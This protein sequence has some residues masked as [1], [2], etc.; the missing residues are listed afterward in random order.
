MERHGRSGP[1]QA[2]ETVLLLGTGGVSSFALQFAKLHGA[3]VVL[4]SSSDA[5]LALAK[6]LGADDVINY[7]DTPDWGKAEILTDGRGVDMVVE[8][9]GPGTLER[10]IR[11]TRVGGH[12]HHWSCVGHRANRSTAADLASDPVAR[13]SCRIAGNV[14]GN[15]RDDNQSSAD[16]RY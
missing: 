15:E 5:K 16:F 2:G 13:H 10:S 6:S 9:G 7:R 3:R 12:C 1:D 14:P 4:T 11:W 8:V